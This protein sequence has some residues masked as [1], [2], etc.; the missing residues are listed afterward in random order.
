LLTRE[1]DTS[2]LLVFS[3][4]VGREQLGRRKRK[5]GSSEFP[6]AEPF[7]FSAQEDL[8]PKRTNDED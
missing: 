2:A 8:K 5:I 4:G 1:L 7:V 6:F 3:V